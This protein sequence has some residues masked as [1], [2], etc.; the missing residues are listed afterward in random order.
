MKNIAIIL[1]SGTGERVGLDIPK[2]FVKIAGRTVL[3]HTLDIFE[4]NNQINEIIIVTNNNYIKD[5]QFIANQY[6]KIT[7]IIEGGK[8]RQESSYKGLCSISEDNA[9]VLIHDA[10]RPFLSQ[11]IIN[12]CLEALEKYDAVDVAV[13]SADTIIQINNK[14]IIENIPNRNDLRRGQTPQ[15]FKLK[16]IKKAHELALLEKNIAVTDDCGLVLKFGLADIYVINGD[17]Y[18]MKITYP[19]DI[20]IADKLFQI[21]TEDNINTDLTQLQK[22]VLVI[23]GGTKGIGAG[24][25]KLA[26]DQGAIV[27]TCS[28][29]TGIDVT[30]PSLI[31]NFL[32]NITDK[33]GRIDYIINTA[34]VLNTGKLNKRNF[35]DIENEVSINYLGS[36]NVTKV[37][38]EYLKRTKGALLLFAS[39]SYTRGRANYAIYSSSKA[40]VVNFTQAIAEEW[41]EE[42]IR[43]NVLNPQRT[44]TSMRFNNF[45]EEP[46]ESLLTV[47]VVAKQALKVLVSNFTGQVVDVRKNIDF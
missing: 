38:Y 28:R 47:E 7:Y 41:A 3:E 36:I 11:R 13:K 2:Q 18:N 35:S 17:D 5:V 6:S 44:A 30:N 9:K 4:K 31:K 27:Y 19:I 14:K 16:T 39:S 46:K 34:G 45:G 33:E 43:I 10:V 25:A 23:I 12:E 8:T 22:K 29:E 15:G 1:A 20:D 32:E 26:K 40:A 21:K 42:N 37:A 24:I